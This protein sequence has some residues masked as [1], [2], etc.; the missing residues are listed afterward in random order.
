MIRTHA[1]Q[2]AALLSVALALPSGPAADAAGETIA[3][4]GSDPSTKVGTVT[5]PEIAAALHGTG[6]AVEPADQDIS[7][8]AR[9]VGTDPGRT[10]QRVD[11]TSTD[12]GFGW[13]RWSLLALLGLPLLGLAFWLLGRRRGRFIL[14][15][16]TA[17]RVA[18]PVA[19]R[20]TGLALDAAPFGTIARGARAVDGGREAGRV[21]H[22]VIDR[23]THEVTD[24]VVRAD[25]G[26]RLVPMRDVTRLDDDR[27]VLSD[28]LGEGHFED[29]LFAGLD[30]SEARRRTERRALHGGAPLLDARADAVVV[31]AP[32][33]LAARMADRARDAR[34][35]VV[36]TDEPVR[37]ERT[38]LRASD[39]THVRPAGATTVRPEDAD[40]AQSIDPDDARSAGA[41]SGETI[42]IR[43]TSDAGETRPREDR[44]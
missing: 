14:E 31:G 37:I 29:T 19:A 42:V 35:A 32:M 7:G 16:R 1:F 40:V 44:G 6:L 10:A 18:G 36:A 24:L 4:L 25:G 11:A 33:D 8:G 2:L 30:A 9:T 20:P 28:G 5:T 17:T 12:R 38:T 34:V 39:T 23:E 27:V 43:P 15:P 26:V 21:E 41:G 22:V 3:G 13:G